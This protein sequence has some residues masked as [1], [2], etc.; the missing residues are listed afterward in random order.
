[1]LAD[2]GIDFGGDLLVA[3][4]GEIGVDGEFG[5]LDVELLEASDLRRGERLVGQVGEGGAAP[6][7][8]RLASGVDPLP[9]FGRATGFGEQLLEAPDVDAAGID[10]QL[11]AA[12]AREDLRAGVVE[13]AAQPPH[14]V[15]HHL[16]G[17]GR[18]VLAPQTL[19]QVVSRHDA[20]GFEP[21]HR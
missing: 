14:V 9:G 19:D 1:M 3:T 8:E 7:G 4:G 12:P 15:L 18:R 13:R 11:I 17:A 21:Q 10:A 2:E 16:G 6:E 5:R 20:I